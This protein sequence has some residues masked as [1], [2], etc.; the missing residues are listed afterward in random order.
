M[1]T[2]LL[3]SIIILLT[4]SLS[5]ANEEALPP[6]KM[7]WSFDGIFGSVDRAAAQRGFQVYKEVCS[8]CHGLNNLYYRNLKDIG[9]SDDEVKEIAKGYTVKDG[10]ND[11]GE[12]FDRPAIPADRFVS[13]YPNEQAARAANNGAHPPDLSL[14]IKARH[15]GANYIYSLLTG[16][17]EPPVDFKLMLGAHYNPYF[18]NDQIAMPPPLTDGQVTY[19]DSTHASVEQMSRDIAVFLQWAAEPEMEHRKSMGLKVIMFLV[20]FTISFYIAKNRIWSNLK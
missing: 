15:D 10:P 17:K 13:S 4:S 5:P 12:M 2:K 11:D 20:V 8:V 3:I 16:Y 19:I 18:P 14:I 1:K 9:F 7:K 6:K